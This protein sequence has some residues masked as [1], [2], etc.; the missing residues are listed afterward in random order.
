[1]NK[2]PARA[3]LVV[4]IASAAV[5]W[6]ADT[7]QW[8]GVRELRP[9]DRI[10]VIQ[11]DQKRFE[12]TFQNATDLSITLQAGQD[13]SVARD[14][15]IRIHPRAC[16]ANHASVDGGIGLA[17]GAI[18]NATAGERFR[19]EGGDITPGALLGGAGIGAGIGAATGGGYQTIYQK[20]R[21]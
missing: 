16:V 4:A 20:G 7:G 14:D 12:G 9:G 1:M 6:P 13:I 10:G 11:S 18:V 21:K 19:N 17:A 3:A 5:A 2:F 15:V 8:T